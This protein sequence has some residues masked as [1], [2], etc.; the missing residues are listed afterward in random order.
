[1]NHLKAELFHFFVS[2]FLLLQVNHLKAELFH[3]FVSFFFFCKWTIWKLSYFI[4]SLVF[5]SSASEPSVVTTHNVAELFHFFVSF[6]FCKWTIWKLRYFI[7]S[8]FV[9]NLA[10]TCVS[11]LKSTQKVLYCPQVKYFFIPFKE[12]RGC[13]TWIT[14]NGITYKRATV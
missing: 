10:V 12:K 9:C 13:H 14:N 3:F 7:S 11:C 5:S 4:S 2:F 1:M 8:F 6:V